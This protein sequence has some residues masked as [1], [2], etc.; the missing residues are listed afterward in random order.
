LGLG[1]AQAIFG[2]K[3]DLT[4]FGKCITGGYPMAGALADGG[5][6]DAPF[7]R[8]GGTGERAYRGWNPVC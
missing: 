4:V 5:C 3:P 1:G 2:V 6:D 8:I 7:G